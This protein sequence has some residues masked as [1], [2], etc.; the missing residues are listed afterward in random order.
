MVVQTEKG[1][2]IE[3]SEIY[4]DRLNI[5]SNPIFVICA[6]AYSSVPYILYR[7]KD[8]EDLNREFDKYNRFFNPMY[9]GE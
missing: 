9:G 7:A 6:R 3:A 2:L 4:T 8:E 5:S 1:K